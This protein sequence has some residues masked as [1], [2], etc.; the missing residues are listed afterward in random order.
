MA[1][2]VEDGQGRCTVDHIALGCMGGLMALV[3][4]VTYRCLLYNIV[5]NYN[6]TNY[7]QHDACT[8]KSIS[9]VKII[10]LFPF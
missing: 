3:A 1:T 8:A 4:I 10:T 7:R 2:V 5:K 9:F 6:K